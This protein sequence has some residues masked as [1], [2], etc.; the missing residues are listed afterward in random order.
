HQGLHGPGGETALRRIRR[1]LH[2]DKDGVAGNLIFDGVDSAA[3]GNPLRRVGRNDGRHCNANHPAL[4]NCT[5]A[6]SLICLVT[7]FPYKMPASHLLDLAC[8]EP[9]SCGKGFFFPTSSQSRPGNTR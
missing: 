9:P 3:H 7:D 1:T 4:P 8:T 6:A 2:V 5:A